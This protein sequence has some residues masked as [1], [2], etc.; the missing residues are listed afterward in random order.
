MDL[1]SKA[2]PQ[3]LYVK[4]FSLYTENIIARI[5]LQ[6]EA[7]GKEDNI[8]DTLFEVLHEQRKGLVSLK[9]LFGPIVKPMDVLDASKA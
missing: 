4:Q 1:L 5:D 8:P 2:Y 3:D 6:L 7:Y 9:N